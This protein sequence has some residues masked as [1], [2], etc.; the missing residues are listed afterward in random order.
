MIRE[1]LILK[2]D[3]NDIERDI[4]QKAAEIIKAGGTV[5][6]PTETVYGIG[7]DTFNEAAVMK[8]FQAKG[9]PADN[10]LIVHVS[11]MD[12]LPLVVSEFPERFYKLAD[13]FW[14]G[15]LTIIMKKTM[16]VPLSV[17]AGLDTVAVRFP[18]NMI[19][20]LLIEFSGTPVCAP[21]A[22]ISGKPS[23]TSFEH[24]FEDLFGKTDAIIQSGR[25]KCGIE[26]TVI[27]LTCK[28]PVILRPGII[29]AEEISS[30]LGIQVYTEEKRSGASRS[31]GMKY[32]HYAPKA[33]MTIFSGKDETV[34]KH[35]TEEAERLSAKH[36]VGILAFKCCEEYDRF[37]C[38]RLTE[39]GSLEEASSNFFE[40]LREFD[41][42]KTEYLLAEAVPSE[43]IG[44]ALMN[45]L[46]KA[47]GYKIKYL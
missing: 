39:S 1:T 2:T 27:D 36:K 9:R 29:T 25:S 41:R 11:D 17:T 5:V 38:I 6:F 21:S 4:I 40:A 34:R 37:Y 44:E 26:S 42:R 28:T 22:N 16:R 20:R 30:V 13:S 24:V 10:P 3:E 12:M 35:I 18:S 19:A 32:R 31:P 8:I 33:V 45:R 43:G 7:A 46:L 15:P 47:S 23:S 14:P